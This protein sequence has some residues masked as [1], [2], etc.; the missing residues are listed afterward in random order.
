MAISLLL[1]TNLQSK[2]QC[3]GFFTRTY[4]AKP[5]TD[6][7]LVLED[8]KKF[9]TSILFQKVCLGW[10]L[11]PIINSWGVGIRMSWL[12]KNEKLISSG[13]YQLAYI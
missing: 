8:R 5:T 9:S 11:S 3:T 6:G 1:Y 2:T 7:L 12:E 13:G 10:K 4:K